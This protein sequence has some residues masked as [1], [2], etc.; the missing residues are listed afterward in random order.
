MGTYI[1][2][3]FGRFDAV[4]YRRPDPWLWLPAAALLLLG[5]L[6][7]LNTT[8]FLG[9][10]KRGDAFH[11]F[12]LHLAHIAVGFVFL[13]ILSQFSLAGLRRIAMPLFIA[14]IV[15]LALLYVPG[16]GLMKG[17]AR[18]WLR[19]GPVIAEPSELVKFALVFFLAKFLSNRQDRIREFKHG[20]LAVF[21]IVGPITLLILKQPDFGSTV[22]I[23]L[24]L[25]AMLWAAGARWQHLAAA[26]GGALG[27][28]TFQ[29]VAKSYRMKRL[30]TFLDPWSVAR[31]AGFQLVQSFI[32]LGEGGKWGVGLGAGRQKMFYLPEAHTDFVF[33]VVGEEF[34]LLGAA[35]VISLFL[36]ILFRGMR[37]AHDE[38]DP[39]ASLLAVGLTALLSIQALIN[40][41]VVIGLIP[42][43]GLPLPFL[44]YGGTSIII[45]MAA[46]GALL[47]L[48]RR[49]AVR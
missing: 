30:T 21:L 11:F 26:G 2:S 27:L 34:G 47:A 7:V 1:K 12:K 15:M 29:A 9:I 14:S 35:I 6:M 45:A 19:L 8:Y 20:P 13:M 23:A 36:V 39:F 28:L 18:R 3:W 5:L 37:I 22:M 40:M 32:A 46:L 44:S 42:T 38:P 41:S 48:G 4:S 49:P 10:E 25:F 24:I 33:A 16:F 43:K 17:G 31:G